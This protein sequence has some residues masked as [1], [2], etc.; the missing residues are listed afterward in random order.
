MNIIIKLGGSLL[1]LPHLANALQTV[2]SQRAEHRCLIVT[3]GGATT[4]VV[5]EWSRIHTLADETAHWLAI[6]SLDLNRR[7]LEQLLGF[8]SVVSREEAE[9]AWDRDPRPLL[10]KT[11]QFL[12]AEEAEVGRSIPHTWDVTSDSL[13]AWIAMRWPAEELILLK[14]VPAPVGLS[15]IDA[16]VAGLVD[17]YFEHLVHHVPLTSW[18]DVRTSAVIQP[19]LNADN[20]ASREFR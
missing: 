8:G 6:A 14:S 3:G 12:A 10:L 16:S 2:L 18:S 19:W 1:N 11:E 5:R 20:N 17:T 4:D 13:A 15:A 7:L 9:Q